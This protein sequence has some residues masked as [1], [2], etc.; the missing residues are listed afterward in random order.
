MNNAD[1]TLL[2]A[3]HRARTSAQDHMAGSDAAGFTWGEETV[4]DLVLVGAHPF[5]KAKAFT[6]KEEGSP[7]GTGADW[8]WWWLGDNNIT[9]GTLV[10]AKRLTKSNKRG[11]WKIDFNYRKGFQRQQLLATA[12]RLKVV[13]TYALYFGTPEYRMPN[14]CVAVPHPSQNDQCQMC[15]RKTVSL[16]PAVVS[17]E[18]DPYDS[19][20]WSVALE[21]LA[22]PNMSARSLEF[23]LFLQGADPTL[24]SELSIPNGATAM[25]K[26]LV[27]SAVL[28]YSSLGWSE[29]F[30]QQ[31]LFDRPGGP[32]GDVDS[33]AYLLS[34]W[35]LNRGLEMNG[36]KPSEAVLQVL[37]GLK[38]APPE[39]VTALLSGD[40][41]DDFSIDGVGGMTVVDLRSQSRE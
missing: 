27:E 29:R 37:R 9:F 31:P 1:T 6:K 33:D 25:A 40:L 39:H 34:Q 16:L 3:F 5:V 24:W 19:Y 8:L 38:S 18:L 32:W 7:D 17:G 22:D 20:E 10:Q 23:D 11:R 41:P 14:Y 15:H 28:M 30:G 12:D 21:D 4:T 13:P 35:Y 36:R 26:S 2:G